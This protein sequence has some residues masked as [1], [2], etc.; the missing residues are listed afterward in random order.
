MKYRKIIIFSV[1]ILGIVVALLHFNVNEETR[2]VEL[3]L[4]KIK[5]L[6]DPHLNVSFPN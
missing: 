1:G 2:A 4:D 6:K 3:T 5:E